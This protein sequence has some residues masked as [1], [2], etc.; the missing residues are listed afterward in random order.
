M[1]IKTVAV[2]P[3][4]GNVHAPVPGNGAAGPNPE[5]AEARL[6]AAR[7]VATTSSRSR[8]SSTSSNHG[9]HCD[10]QVRI[11]QHPRAAEATTIV[12]PEIPGGSAA[13]AAASAAATAAAVPKGEATSEA[14]AE[15]LAAAAASTP[16]SASTGEASAAATDEAEGGAAESG[17]AAASR[18]G[19]VLGRSRISVEEL[20]RL[21]GPDKR[22]NAQDCTYPLRVI[23]SCKG[24]HA[25]FHPESGLSTGST[26]KIFQHYVLKQRI[27][28][29][30]WGEV[31]VAIERLSGIQRAVKRIPKSTPHAVAMA[32]EE[33]AL[34]REMDH[35]NIV[36]VFECYDDTAYFFVVMELCR[37][38]E[39]FDELAKTATSGGHLPDGRPRPRFSRQ[40]AALI[41]YQ[42]LSAAH[43]CHQHGICHRDIK[44]EN[45]LLAEP[46]SLTLKLADFGL[47]RRF[48]RRRS[49]PRR[50]SLMDLVEAAVAAATPAAAPT[51][52]SASAVL[53]AAPLTASGDAAEG[54]QT[55]KS[56]A[57]EGAVAQQ[58]QQQEEETMLL[59]SVAGTVCFAAP[60]VLRLSADLVQ[61][62]EEMRRQQ[63]G[64]GTAAVQQD[65]E[66]GEQ[67]E[68]SQQQLQQQQQQQLHPW[69]YDGER[70]DAWSCGVMLYLLLCG[71]LPFDGP[72]DAA[73]AYNVLHGKLKF[74]HPVWKEVSEETLEL[75]IALLERDPNW[76]L[77]VGEALGSSF[78][79]TDSWMG[80]ASATPSR[81]TPAC[82]FATATA[83]LSSVAAAAAAGLG[84]PD[85]A[86]TGPAAPASC[87]DTKQ[88]D[89]AS[90]GCAG[91][92][93][94][95][96]AGPVS[97]DASPA[98]AASEAAPETPAV[99]AADDKCR[100]A[101]PSMAAAA[102]ARLLQ[103][104]LAG[105]HRILET[106]AA[107][108]AAPTAAEVSA[109]LASLPFSRGH[110]AVPKWPWEQKPA[111][112]D[113]A[114]AAASDKRLDEAGEQ[115]QQEQ[116]GEQKEKQLQQQQ[117]GIMGTRTRLNF[118]EDSS[119]YLCW[120][121]NAFIGG[122]GSM[123]SNSCC[124]GG[125]S[126]NC[127]S[128][129]RS[130]AAFS[131]AG[132]GL[133]GK[134]WSCATG[135][136]SHPG[137]TSSASPDSCSCSRRFVSSSTN[138][139]S[140]RNMCFGSSNYS[141]CKSAPPLSLRRRRYKITARALIDS[142]GGGVLRRNESSSPCSSKASSRRE[143]SS[144]TDATLL[145]NGG[146][147]WVQQGP[148]SSS[149]RSLVCSPFDAVGADA[150]AA[151]AG[152]AA[153]TPATAAA[154]AGATAA[155]LTLAM[156]EA[157]A[158]GRG[159]QTVRHGEQQ[160]PRQK[161]HQQDLQQDL[162]QEF[163][164][165]SLGELGE[166]QVPRQREPHL[167]IPRR[168]ALAL[169]W[170]QALTLA[171]DPSSSSSYSSNAAG[172]EGVG[173]LA[174]IWSGHPEQQLLEQEGDFIC[175]LGQQE[176][177]LLHY[178]VA[179]EELLRRLRAATQGPLLR[180]QALLALA[181]AARGSAP[182]SPCP[183][184]GQQL[185][186]LPHMWGDPFSNRC[187]NNNIQSCS[188]SRADFA[189]V[190][191]GAE[192]S[193]CSCRGARPLPACCCLCH[194]A[195]N[196]RY[197]PGCSSHQT[198]GMLHASC[199]SSSS[200]QI[201]QTGH[202][203][204]SSV[205]DVR[206][207][208]QQ[209]RQHHWG[210][211]HSSSMRCLKSSP[212]I[213]ELQACSNSSSSTSG[214]LR[215]PRNEAGEELLRERRLLQLLFLS[216]DKD[217]DGLLS[218]RDFADGMLSL[219]LLSAILGQ[220]ALHPEEDA[221]QEQAAAALGL[222]TLMTQQQHNQQNQQQNLAQTQQQKEQDQPLEQVQHQQKQANDQPL[223]QVQQQQH[224]EQQQ[225]EDVWVSWVSRWLVL[226]FELLLL[227][228]EIDGDGSGAI[229]LSE[230]LAAT[231]D[232]SLLAAQPSLRK[233]AFRMLD[234]SGDGVL[235]LAD[236]K[237][238]VKEKC[239]SREDSEALDLQLQAILSAG[240][241][242]GDGRVTLQRGPSSL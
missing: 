194:S 159:A 63:Q 49:V 200:R 208:Q 162:Q 166:T 224:Q 179:A 188:S 202:L 67:A 216:F 108:A 227:G 100:V 111:T 97:P 171:S 16:A 54:E 75:V 155:A 178:T 30:S 89:A 123:S 140:S 118:L 126:S 83:A 28:S 20:Q 119:C 31:F 124:S 93:C 211:N 61:K 116:Q 1:A 221:A 10:K 9:G 144:P 161:Q 60:E 149:P 228:A 130:C 59:Q 164:Q 146:D 35:P 195:S 90:S 99:G 22:T 175:T 21:Y 238:C 92:L 44:P 7:E 120:C 156:Q 197:L 152:A 47:A 145:P 12:A 79:S 77:L 204:S 225:E 205:G 71:E 73:V 189:A 66:V 106:C 201:C 64:G 180:R 165:V 45:F 42:V 110:S 85:A 4:T 114:I 41:M 185:L 34:M 237:A 37:G 82:S 160:H 176:L 213:P 172:L 138:S 226:H 117:A 154:L 91:T 18:R 192:A 102:T 72:D 223:E 125:R 143:S 242:D 210:D 198:L 78:F 173:C 151:V 88:T 40:E 212:C 217:G 196:P 113:T 76:R 234:R 95:G 62:T 58:Q 177:H 3:R 158:A 14:T 186:H 230:F 81:R 220:L 33:V 8:N 131:P 206:T 139:S 190:G 191:A 46:G 38:G 25:E 135:C 121:S 26:S 157:A 184:V 27:G 147:I 87:A 109:C 170:L 215:G 115:Q 153:A 39:L 122:R 23:L 5:H 222:D 133:S 15:T 53:L 231:L 127:N 52:P 214:R 17:S 98:A 241:V 132:D 236:L 24:L 137:G 43:C 193:C 55:C 163:L 203:H 96:T 142:M 148:P 51:T 239:L 129:G 187:S 134:S 74:T 19:S 150:G 65:S 199:S 183:S 68:G 13:E 169:H 6:A 70:A 107:V 112:A 2:S 182:P 104:R 50:E 209:Q 207:Q 232:S 218:Y 80:S 103:R 136:L 233:A 128:S 94:R 168:V 181:V 229:E 48:S 56:Q 219:L 101:N 57:T 11:M 36:K 32:R 235:G 240:D 84:L 167:H 69:G 141:S 105:L 29:G 174:S 86:S